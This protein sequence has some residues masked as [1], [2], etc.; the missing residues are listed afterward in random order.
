MWK[1]VVA[2]LSLVLVSADAVVWSK[3]KCAAAKGV[4]KDAICC[5]TFLRCGEF[6]DS[7]SCMKVMLNS[8]SYCRNLGIF[9]EILKSNFVLERRHFFV[10]F[11]V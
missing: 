9:S 4:V 3:A 8:H 10:F 6:K 2:V 7:G 5:E 1:A 11:V